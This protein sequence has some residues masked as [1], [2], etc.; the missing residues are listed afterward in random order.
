[1]NKNLVRKFYKVLWDNHNKEE[2][3]SVLHENFTFRGSLGDEKR[4]HAG[5]AEYVDMVH[6]ALGDYKCIIEEIVAEDNKVFTKMTFTGIHRDEFMGYAATQKRISWKGCALF[7][8]ENELIKDV[9]VLGDLM[10][11]EKQL[12]KSSTN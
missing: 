4:G 6:K 11:L 8:F 9:W 12:K 7:T 3:P 2:M 5:F 1:M 10:S